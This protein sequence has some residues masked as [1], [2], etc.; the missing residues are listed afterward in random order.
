VLCY[1]LVFAF[2]WP[3][4]GLACVHECTSCP[5]QHHVM[6]RVRFFFMELAEVCIHLPLACILF[7]LQHGRKKYFAAQHSHMHCARS[8]MCAYMHMH[9]YV[10]VYVYVYVYVHTHTHIHTHTQ[11]NVCTHTH[12][13]T[14]L[15]ICIYIYIYIYIY[16]YAYNRRRY[17]TRMLCTRG[18]RRSSYRG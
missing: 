12:T 11:M 15:Y 1:D 5:G 14:H 4:Y 17:E 9:P 16:T 13:H 18:S 10:H 8:Y 7:F 3:V 2:I 6:F